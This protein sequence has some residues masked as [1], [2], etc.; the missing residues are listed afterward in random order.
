MVQ[1]E[2]LRDAQTNVH[3]LEGE[4]KILK[5]KLEDSASA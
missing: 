2:K 3:R 5:D 1:R 4:V